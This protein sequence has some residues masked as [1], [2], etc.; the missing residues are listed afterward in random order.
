M[1]K[2]K[3]TTQS[4]VA[5]QNGARGSSSPEIGGRPLYEMVLRYAGSADEH[6]K[7][8]W[9]GLSVQC[10]RNPQLVKRLAQSNDAAKVRSIITY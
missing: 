7:W 10:A 5:N 3:L 2:R 4:P 6:L 1:P 8:W 9:A